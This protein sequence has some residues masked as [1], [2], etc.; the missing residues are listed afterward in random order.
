[1]FRTTGQGELGACPAAVEV[2]EAG[3]PTII[4][5]RD[6]FGLASDFEQRFYLAHE[7]GHY[8]MQTGIEE[9][10]DAFALGALAGTERK[11]LKQSLAALYAMPT[12]PY[13]RLEA[14]ARRCE[15][16]D[17][18]H[19]KLTDMAKQNLNKMYNANM[20]RADGETNPTQTTTTEAAVVAKQTM[21]DAATAASVIGDI[22]VGNNRRRAG[23][24]INNVFFS[25]ESI[26]LSAIL[27]VAVVIACKK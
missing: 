5:N 25:L 8:I 17:R 27:I 4:I 2:D 22:L 1:M 10:A 12:I 3:K 11:S 7:L 9:V 6:R 26:I 19:K 16:I 24:R 21:A 18:N 20:L 14:M 13:G 15:Q 23:I